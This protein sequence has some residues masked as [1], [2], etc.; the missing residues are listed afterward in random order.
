MSSK[1]HL[2]AGRRSGSQCTTA[3]DKMRASGN[4]GESGAA[5]GDADWRK[6]NFRA[7]APMRKDAQSARSPIQR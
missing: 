7:S 2:D 5:T 6:L 1:W 4:D 3:P